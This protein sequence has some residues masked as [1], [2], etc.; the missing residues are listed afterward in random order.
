MI[1]TTGR[2]RRSAEVL[3]HSSERNSVVPW[4]RP[5][6]P[7]S[8]D[9]TLATVDHPVGSCPA[10]AA[11]LEWRIATGWGVA[12]QTERLAAAGHRVEA[13][14]INAPDPAVLL[15]R[16]CCRNRT[17]VATYVVVT[18]AAALAVGELIHVPPSA[19]GPP[20]CSR[21]ASFG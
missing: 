2:R 3:E 4:A 7:R 5:I 6:L 21:R 18:R 14:V 19:L 20:E 15:Q 16:P 8:T 17:A 11:T 9:E 10:I 12:G 1:R 13:V